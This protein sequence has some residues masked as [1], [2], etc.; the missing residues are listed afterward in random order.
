MVLLVVL[1]LLARL[2]IKPPSAPADSG[3]V[4][5]PLAIGTFPTTI[6]INAAGKVVFVHTGQYDAQAALDND[7]R[8]YALGRSG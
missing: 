3:G 6:F 4:P 1:A 5:A 2:D 8:R 7:I